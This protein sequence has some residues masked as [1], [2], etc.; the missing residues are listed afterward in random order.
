V[1]RENFSDFWALGRNRKRRAGHRRRWPLCVRQGDGRRRVAQALGFHFLDS[2]ALY[3][4]VALAALRAGVPPADE[5]AVTAL[6]RGL[7]CHFEGE[8]VYLSGEAVTDAIRTEEVSLAASK[9]A[10]HPLVRT[11]LLDRQRVFRRPPGLVAD[12]RD[13]G[14]IV[15]PGAKLKVFL[16]ASAEERAQRRHKQLMEKGIDATLPLCGTST[17]AMRVTPSVAWRRYCAVM[18]PGYWIPYVDGRAGRQTVWYRQAQLTNGIPSMCSAR[19]F[20]GSEGSLCS[21]PISKLFPMGL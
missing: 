17:S 8:A 2:G 13:M 16:T 6:A 11:A 19:S 3:R 18:M 1:C 9:V 14:S 15:F 5:E 12:G 4:L 7:D 10:A 20:A 21:G